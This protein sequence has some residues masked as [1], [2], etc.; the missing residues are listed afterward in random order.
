MNPVRYRTL[1][2]LVTNL[3]LFAREPFPQPAE[4]G[5]YPMQQVA[6]AFS[7]DPA[8]LV[9]QQHATASMRAGSPRLGP[10]MLPFTTS[11]HRLVRRAAR[12]GS[13]V[14]LDLHTVE[15][16]ERIGDVGVVRGR[17]QALI[18]AAQR[19]RAVDRVDKAPS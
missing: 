17:Q 13:R 2:S 5:R 12:P 4:P 1:A 15:R 7:I 10:V 14:H 11:D 16:G 18:V 6:S 3:Q 19:P 8:R 9:G